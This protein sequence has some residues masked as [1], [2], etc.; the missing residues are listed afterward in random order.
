MWLRQEDS[1]RQVSDSAMPVFYGPKSWFADMSKK[2]IYMYIILGE[3]Y[4][5]PYSI[6]NPPNIY[7]N[8]SAVT[9]S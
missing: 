4:L 5:S 3:D 9:Q 1:E 2:L 7:Y 8:W 6:A